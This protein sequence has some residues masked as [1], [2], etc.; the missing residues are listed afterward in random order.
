M[1]HRVVQILQVGSFPKEGA[2]L[3]EI[4]DIDAIDEEYDDSQLTST[5]DFKNALVSGVSNMFKF[6]SCKCK[7]KVQ[8][9]GSRF[10]RCSIANCNMLQNLDQ[11][12]ETFSAILMITSKD[13]E[14][15]EI[16]AFERELRNIAD[17][18]DDKITK[19]ISGSTHIFMLQ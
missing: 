1:S 19:K 8:I 6:R 4:P 13:K 11:S 3:D 14:K 15:M 2:S 18:T 12:K 7:S 10:G 5:N 17:I 16:H 9:T